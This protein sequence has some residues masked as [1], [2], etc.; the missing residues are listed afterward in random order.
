MKTLDER[1]AATQDLIAKAKSNI[2]KLQGGME[3][4]TTAMVAAQGQLGL[5]IE[6]KKEAEAEAEA[7]DESSRPK[8][9]TN[10]RRRAPAE[11]V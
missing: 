4:Q 3:Q 2:E 5:L 9:P 11:T 8:G 6:L 7:K 10:P 1:I